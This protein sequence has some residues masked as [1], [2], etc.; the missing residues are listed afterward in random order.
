MTETPEVPRVSSLGVIGSRH[1]IAVQTFDIARLTTHPVPIVPGTFVAVSGE[2]PRGDSNGSG[3][4]SF[5]VAVSILLGDPQWRFD[6]AG[7]KAAA[8]VLFLPDSAGVDSERASAAKSGYIVGVFAHE[9]QPR[10]SA[11]TVW[12]HLETSKPYLEAVWAEGVHL[13][14]DE[15]LDERD[16]QADAIW[17]SL[18]RR[19]RLSARRM[20]EELYGDA[21]RCLTYLDTPLRPPVPSLLSQQMTEMQP[22]DIG[23]SLIALSGSKAHLDA[24]RKQRGDVLVQR[25]QRDDALERAAAREREVA[26]EL[27]AIEQ[28]DAAR[29]ALNAAEKWWDGYVTAQYRKV[30]EADVVAGQ[31]IRAL[32]EDYDE[33]H[34]RAEAAKEILDELIGATELETAERRVYDLWQRARERTSKLREQRAAHSETQNALVLER[35]DLRPRTDGWDGSSSAS[36]SEALT[37]AERDVHRTEADR[38]A[39]DAAVESGRAA[40]ERAGNGRVGL[41]GLALDALADADVA[42]AALFDVL[43]LDE[44]A[45]GAWE[46]RISQYEHAVVV[47]HGQLSQACAALADLPGVVVIGTDQAKTSLP[48]GIRCSWGIGSFLHELAERLDHCTE[49]DRVQDPVLAV[50]IVGGFPDP[51]AGRDV[52]LAQLRRHLAYAEQNAAN[53]RSKL[54]LAQSAAAL[55]A[56]R[57]KCAIAA[58]RLRSV[59][60][61]ERQVT[62]RVSGLDREIREAT[63]HEA[64]VQGEWERARDA[65]S[66]RTGKIEVLQAQHARFQEVERSKLAR[67]NT[68]KTE[69]ENLDVE[70]W[71]VLAAACVPTEEG[72]EQTEAVHLGG[73]GA[74][75]VKAIDH[76]ADAIRLF[77]FDEGQESMPDEIRE[78]IGARQ[79]LAAD[80]GDRAPR[81]GLREIAAPLRSRLEARAGPDR[82]TKK[83]IHEERAEQALIHESLEGDLRD[84]EQRLEVLQHM[85]S[86]RIEGVLNR[87]SVRFGQLDSDRSGNGAELHFVPSLPHGAAEWVWEVTPRWKRSRSGGMVSY[88][89]IANGA[90]VK[91]Y[92]VQL[93]LAAVLAD[94][95]THGRVLV[96]DELGNSLGEVNRKDVLGALNRVAEDTQVTILGTCQDSVV[97]DAAD[98][99]GELLWF[100]HTSESEAYNRPTRVWGFTENGEQ[101]EL[102]AEQMLSGRRLRSRDR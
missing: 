54:T 99:C 84:S 46:P 82:V 101:V 39:A 66:G 13:A 14:D 35:N 94:K 18:K 11:I 22:K 73:L 80:A 102:T 27:E 72:S 68:R 30:L 90:Q 62:N 58:E 33:A 20:A 83:R 55:A 92:A 96:L 31:D 26:A 50:T 36:T 64:K 67:L 57:H 37:A 71:G 44:P 81:L 5:L 43:E 59:N 45:R 16:L 12:V 77:G 34:A 49:P 42:G 17:K 95:E 74:T 86:Q 29:E 100:A 52:L 24:E 56:N 47:H 41:A 97:V 2:G 88:R 28:R 75:R 21:P 65:V 32:A 38:D 63:T 6:T 61:Q 51:I 89:E 87:I 70:R 53:V 23:E 7:G 93:V 3:K 98:V 40:V 1:L 15:D 60:E 4:T 79:Q 69:R 48:E 85:I 10:E 76:L 9:E 78:L 8:G 91:V 19:G 25:R